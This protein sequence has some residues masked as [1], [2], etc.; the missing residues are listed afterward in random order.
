M[1]KK[2][3]PKLLSAI[4]VIVAGMLVL[5]FTGSE[6]KAFAEN[7]SQPKILVSDKLKN[8]PLAM[9]IIAE[10]EAQKLR[11]KQI[12]EG[13]ITEVPLTKEQ[14]EVEETRKIVNERLQEDLESMEKDYL[15]FTPRNAFAKF[16]EKLNET[17]H[18]IFWDQF[19]YLEAK[20]QL[21]IAAKNLVLENGGSFYDSQREY[22]KYASMPRVDM[23]NYIKELNIKYGF[24]DPEIQAYFDEDGKL[25]RF[26]NDND[27]PCYGCENILTVEIIEPIENQ[28]EISEKKIPPTEKKTEPTEKKITKIIDVTPQEPNN[29]LKVLNERLSELRA[30]FLK[31]TDFNQKKV[32]VDSLNDTVKKI[33]NLKY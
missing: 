25:P 10:M 3:I 26:E 22:F 6:Q 32:L 27:A 1:N 12:S 15:D 7:E 31:S 5:S 11:Y 21:A 14:I 24:A 28:T 2:P 18:G 9:K 16:V 23:I 19:D 4:T 33:Q 30:E 20:V 29:E 13:Q 8:N 17:Y